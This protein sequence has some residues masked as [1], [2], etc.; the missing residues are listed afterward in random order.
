MEKFKVIKLL[1]QNRINDHEVE[2]LIEYHKMDDPNTRNEVF[3]SWFF[4]TPEIT[5]DNMRQYFLDRALE[6]TNIPGDNPREFC[7]N[8]A[9]KKYKYYSELLDI[10]GRNFAVGSSCEG[11][12]E[13]GGIAYEV[14]EMSQEEFENPGGIFDGP[15]CDNDPTI[16]RFFHPITGEIV[17]P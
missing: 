16:Y 7:E 17:R 14:C 13:C 4:T 15:D 10:D 6:C 8:Y 11:F 12:D 2:F 9:D 5:P 1:V 3:R